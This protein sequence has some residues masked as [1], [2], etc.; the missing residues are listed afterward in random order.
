M[1]ATPL[2]A[3]VQATR[4]SCAQAALR[5]MADLGCDTLF[6]LPGRAIFPLLDELP[7]VPELGYVTGLHEF[8][9]AAIADGWARARGTAAFVSLYMSTGT[10][11]AAS[12]I[13]LAQRDRIP[14]VVT[15]TQAESWAVGANHRAE[16][17]DVVEAMRPITKWA[18]MPPT[19]QRVPEALRRAY[20][21]AMTPPMGP[22]FLSIPV[23]FWDAEIEYRPPVATDRVALD[24]AGG[25]GAI[26]ELAERLLAASAPCLVVGGEAI[27]DGVPEAL[28]RLATMLGCGLVAEPEP[29]RLPAPTRFPYFGG[30]VA[31]ACDLIA[32]SDLVVHVAVNTYEAFHAQIFAAGRPKAH[33]W[34]GTDSL[35]LNKVVPAALALAGPVAPAVHALVRGV[36]ERLGAQP[37]PAFAQRGERVVAQIAA[38]RA[39]VE[40]ARDDGWDA[41]PMSVPRAVAEI[42]A[43]LPP[44]TIV[45]DHST[46]AIRFVRECFP[47]P[48]GSQ[49]VSA[50]GSCQGWGLGAAVGVQLADRRR[51]VVGFVGDGGFMFGVQ[52]WW[53][54]VQYELPLLVVVLDNAGWSSADSQVSQG[55]RDAGI[56]LHFGWQSDYAQIARGIGGDA[57]RVTTPAE[58]THVLRERLPLRRPLLLD[59]QCRRESKTS[60]SPYVGY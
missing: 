4:M 29:P 59:V 44:E 20:S 40:R 3:P 24:V 22:V 34:I 28:Q 21:I 1:T 15:A 39:P 19:P 56:D 30:S 18:W 37:A 55:I 7:N 26:A 49:Y 5:S 2:A 50:S 43:Q 42:R 60:P 11:N 32:E 58:L 54:A 12:A 52:A 35:E 46:T 38:E 57:E 45:V 27:R 17:D 14:L 13:F 48:D 16:I 8:P 51:P 33:V 25:S 47:V 10:L 6:N 9:L 41:Q 53:T 23:D 31:E 36:E